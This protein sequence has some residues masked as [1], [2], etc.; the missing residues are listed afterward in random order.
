MGQL[1]YFAMIGD[2]VICFICNNISQTKINVKT[3]IIREFVGTARMAMF[4]KKEDAFST[5]QTS[6]K[7]TG[8]QKKL[9]RM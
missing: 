5:T 4:A 7:L 8:K 3:F 2:L 9:W 1:P 6:L